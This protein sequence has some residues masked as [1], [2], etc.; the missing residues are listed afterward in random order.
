MNTHEL[1]NLFLA[2]QASQN[3]GVRTIEWYRYEVSR[4]FDWLQANNL[5]NGNWL[6]ASVINTYLAA[7][8]KADRSPQRKEKKGN[9]PA[10]IAGHYRGLHALFCLAERP[11][12]H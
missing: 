7:S 12:L 8:R 11:G 10:T 4:F 9:E 5:H 6:Q 2:A 1:L 3:H